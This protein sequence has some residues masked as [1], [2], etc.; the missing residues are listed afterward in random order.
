MTL[1][2]R[3]RD[4]TFHFKRSDEMRI[5]SIIRHF[6]KLSRWQSL[7]KFA[8]QAFFNETLNVILSQ[9]AGENFVLSTSRQTGSKVCVMHSFIEDRAKNACKFPDGRLGTRKWTGFRQT[10][11]KGHSI[12]DPRQYHVII[13]GQR[14]LCPGHRFLITISLRAWLSQLFSFAVEG[15][16]SQDSG[17]YSVSMMP[18]YI[19][20]I[21]AAITVH[22]LPI[23][24]LGVNF[25]CSI[26]RE[27]SCNLQSRIHLDVV[28][29]HVD[30][31]FFYIGDNEDK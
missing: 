26:F 8:K 10:Q 21:T 23:N 14:C 18:N 6:S 30:S 7:A 31:R 20:F 16:S 15:G 27:E 13:T 3:R 17:W 11:A 19:R 29:W 22:R 5:G 12:F 4:A 25:T 9:F 28:L 24:L 1:K 2:R